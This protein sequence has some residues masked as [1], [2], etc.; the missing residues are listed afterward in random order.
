VIV[1]RTILHPITRRSQVNMMKMQ[2][3]MA[4]LQ[5]KVNAVKEKYA[6]DRAAMNQ[7]M[8]EVYKDAGVNPAGSMLTC[9]PMMLQLP[10]WAALWTALNSTVEMRHAAFD[11]WWIRDLTQPDALI[12]F[13]AGVEIPLLSYVMGGP[14][15]SF[16]LLPILLAISQLIQA[17]F[18]PRSSAPAAGGN[19]DQMEQQRKMMMFMSV[20]FL[21]LF[22]NMPSGLNLYIMTSNLAGILEQ[23]RIR[24]HIAEE[25]EKAKFAPPPGPKPKGWFHR[26]WEELQKEA[27]EVKRI[28][29]PKA[30]KR[31]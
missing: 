24:K 11:G 14:I 2:K 19:P 10:I 31:K 9:L 16:N 30:K 15:H 28:Q 26:K 29:S 7:A 8:M 25:E 21:F 5:P 17:K 6:N 18:M 12:A 13:S 22:Y 20:F 1:V 3:Q 23:W 27:E 4:S